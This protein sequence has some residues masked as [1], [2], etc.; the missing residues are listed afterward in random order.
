MTARQTA[1]R[2][3]PY[4]LT[5]LAALLVAAVASTAHCQQ[6]NQ[7][8]QM[9]D[10]AFATATNNRAGAVT[11]QTTAGQ[12]LGN[13]S[14]TLK[15]AVESFQKNQAQMTPEQTQKYHVYVGLATAAFN[16]GNTFYELALDA[17]DTG[18]VRMA[19]GNV[20]YGDGDYAGA[21]PCYDCPSPVPPQEDGAAQHFG[22]SAALF[23]SS[24]AKYQQALQYAQTAGQWTQVP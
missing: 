7:Q 18:D 21:R 3:R 16:D 22:N 13:F 8:K 14:A 19:A 2:A 5:A 17:L 1:R 23:Q 6:Q 24:Q 12:V 4:A 10:A 9:A 20:R 11:N 15:L